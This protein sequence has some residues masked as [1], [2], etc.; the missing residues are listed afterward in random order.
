MSIKAIFNFILIKIKRV[1]ARVMKIILWSTSFLLMVLV[2]L[3]LGLIASIWWLRSD[4]GQVW[5]ETQIETVAAESGYNVQISGIGYAF[6]QSINIGTLE[7]FDMQGAIVSLTDTKLR[8][9]LLG[10]GLKHLDLSLQSKTLILHRIPET[11]E[12][13]D[14]DESF[15]LEPFVLPNPYFTSF[16]FSD[17]SVETFEIRPEVFGQEM[18]LSPRLKSEITLGELIKLDLSLYLREHNAGDPPWM[19][20]RLDLNGSFD[21]QTL[22]VVLE[23][24]KIKSDVVQ[25]SANGTGNLGKDGTIHFET[26]AELNDLSAFADGIEGETHIEAVLDGTLSAPS[27]VVQGS[28]DLPLLKERGLKTI[29]LTLTDPDLST[30]ASG[31]FKISTAYQSMPVIV[32]ADFDYNAPNIVL[33]NIKG[34]A[35]NASIK[36]GVSVNTDT[37][38]VSGDAALIIDDLQTYATLA[39]FDLAGKGIVNIG[40]SGL[41]Q[42][43]TIKINASANEV[44]YDTIF[45]KSLNTT[46]EITDINNP[47]PKSLTLNAKGLRPSK[48]IS[49][50]TLTATIAD[51]GRDIYRLD[52]N[53]AGTALQ[54][55]Q[56]KGGA[57]ITGVSA[58]TVKAENMDLTL[59]SKGSDIH[60]AG[61]ADR[62]ALDVTIASKDFDLA[63]LPVS[64]PEQMRALSFSTKT[65]VK[66]S[67]D[68]PVIDADIDLSPVTITDKAKIKLN[69]KASYKEGHAQVNINGNGNG[70][71]ALRGSVNIPLKLSFIPFVMDADASTPLDGQMVIDTKARSLAPLLLPPTHNLTGDIE[72]NGTL[73]GTIGQPDL[74]GKASVQNGTYLYKPIGV[75]L[76][77]IGMRADLNP[78][79]I[80][81][82][83]LYAEDGQNGTLSGAGKVSIS[84][85]Q[86]T[87]VDINLKDFNLL[88]SDMVKGTISSDL[89]LNGVSDTAYLLAG[90]INLGKFDIIIPERFQSTIPE[91]NV[92]KKQDKNIDK[93]SL[94]VVRLD[95]NIIANNQ[96]FVRGWGLDAEF[97]GNVDVDGTLDDPQLNGSLKSR[98]GRY[99]E[100]GRRFTLERAYLRFQGSA[101]PS[102]YLD[103]VATT[104]ADDIK[105]SVNLSGEVG[106]PS[107]T[108][109]SV[110]SLPQD[111]IMSRVLFGRN[112]QKITPF[113]AIQL[114]N[115]LDRFSGNGGGGFDPL[116]KLRNITGLS[117]IRVDTDSEGDTSVG[118][119]KYLTDKVYL[120]LEKGTGEGSGAAKVQVEVT[121]SISVESEVGQDAQAG[122]AVQW[123]WDY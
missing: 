99:E 112:L 78:S 100:F 21:P 76:Y 45:I 89:N 107:I 79:G 12:I 80:N 98:R 85:P 68:N 13:P 30:F 75:H 72:V 20:D 17:L 37:I 33:Q 116:G 53:G 15:A 104:D 44:K 117:D 96:I 27:L 46:T 24:L 77:N 103:I 18:V 55:F 42:T 2:T 28:A 110:P 8:P 36:G 56:I 64:L 3:Q 34:S 9:G 23:A 11:Q 19:P 86:G 59:S 84:G 66:G 94:S 92:I 93:Q 109:S 88:D 40:L 14:S 121:P 81:L 25:I 123:R 120:E 5:L 67:M 48:D 82:T 118:V 10:L 105:A 122:A 60:A 58:D 61:W 47:I 39:G 62:T 38:L 32:E 54:K 29:T 69:A 97:G 1:P 6:P 57:D 114:K 119:G 73:S 52:I 102:P 50:Q 26:K 65:Q 4:D 43:Q 113:Q 90:D 83:K 63:S 95:L 71:D 7:V 22:D 115:T 91:L 74:S 31:D 106:N 108:L 49:F 51:K 41:E 111:E 101:P 87:N 16:S 35:P 70:I